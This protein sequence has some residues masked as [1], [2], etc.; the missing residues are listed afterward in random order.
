MLLR[1]VAK[2]VTVMPAQ[3]WASGAWIG[4]A[5]GATVWQT[6]HHMRLPVDWHWLFLIAGVTTIVYTSCQVRWHLWRR[7]TALLSVPLFLLAGLWL[8]EVTNTTFTVLL[9]AAFL[10]LA[11]Y[12]VL[13][14]RTTSLR[15]GTIAKPLTLSMV[16]VLAVVLAPVSTHLSWLLP[17]AWLY[18]FEKFFLF[19]LLAILSDVYDYEV[20]L[21]QGLTT[22][23]VAFG[24]MR[25]RPLILLLILAASLLVAVSTYANYRRPLEAM[26]LLLTYGSLACC[27]LLA[28]R[29]SARSYDRTLADGHLVLQAALLMAV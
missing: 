23:P 7:F 13:P 15:E 25:T 1:G 9:M 27:V 8:P 26:L 28:G 11:Y 10:L 5:A 18:V 29:R 3:G 20:D 17:S 22:L 24:L 4:L 12:R 16:W 2:A 6:Q 19:L 14:G 21:R